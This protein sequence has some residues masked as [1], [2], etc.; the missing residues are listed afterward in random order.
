ME[1]DAPAVASAVAGGE[2]VGVH[3]MVQAVAEYVAAD[4][5]RHSL[6]VGDILAVTAVE[7]N[8][9]TRGFKVADPEHVE[10]LFPSSYIRPVKLKPTQSTGAQPEPE[11]APAPQGLAVTKSTFDRARAGLED[12]IGYGA[13]PAAGLVWTASGTTL[14]ATKSKFDQARVGLMGD[15]DGE[16]EEGGDHDEEEEPV[17]MSHRR[18]FVQTESTSRTLC[19]F[20]VT[21]DGTHMPYSDEDNAAIADAEARGVEC[22]RLSPVVLPDGQVLRFEVRFGAAAISSRL[23]QPPASGII[24]VNLENDFTREVIKKEVGGEPS[25]PLNFSD[26]PAADPSFRRSSTPPR[27]STPPLPLSLSKQQSDA[28]QTEKSLIAAEIQALDGQAAEGLALEPVVGE[29]ESQASVQASPRADARDLA[30]HAAESW[31]DIADVLVRSGEFGW[32]GPEFDDGFSAIDYRCYIDGLGRGLIQAFERA[33]VGASTHHVLL[34]SGEVHLVKLKRRGNKH[35][36]WLVGER[37]MRAAGMRSP[38]AEASVRMLTARMVPIETV[39]RSEVADGD[40]SLSKNSMTSGDG[41]QV[42]IKDSCGAG[43][44]RG[45]DLQ[46]TVVAMDFACGTPLRLPGLLNRK[47]FDPEEPEPEPEPA[48]AADG[49]PQLQL[50]ERDEC[51]ETPHATDDASTPQR[52]STPPVSGRQETP[53]ERHLRLSRS[54]MVSKVAEEEEKHLRQANAAFAASRTES[55]VRADRLFETYCVVGAPTTLQEPLQ[56]LLAKWSGHEENLKRLSEQ[57]QASP[58]LLSMYPPAEEIGRAELLSSF[59]FADRVSFELNLVK[60]LPPTPKLQRTVFVMVEGSENPTPLY[61]CCLHTQEILATRDDMHVVAPRCYCIVS[62]VPCLNAH[63]ALLECVLWHERKERKVNT[64]VE[65]MVPRGV[66]DQQPLGPSI[67]DFSDASLALEPE[68]DVWSLYY[69]H[70]AECCHFICELP[71]DCSAYEPLR[72]RLPSA[73]RDRAHEGSSDQTDESDIICM[74]MVRE[75]KVP[76]AVETDTAGRYCYEPDRL[77][78]RWP[79]G[80]DSLI[81]NQPYGGVSVE[82][83]EWSIA[84]VFEIMEPDSFMQMVR[85]RAG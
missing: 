24:Q 45:D 84:T 34:D 5:H 77:M 26:Q 82:L 75:T 61:G 32:P 59:C 29:A 31:E 53:E 44:L 41:S 52:T 21:A 79:K 80:G 64:V 66:P 35:T 14:P 57:D 69:N 65:T 51:P 37:N 60:Q 36:P 19:Y 23:S 70:G 38:S 27:A 13:E 43:L 25:A 62:R 49:T 8:G 83:A 1:T 11:P 58:E 10:L 33:F 22:Q 30:P 40:A 76:K 71:E 4:S 16:D 47:L 73:W 28:I 17:D 74:S 48:P 3:T 50:P 55:M 39:A 12:Q 46:E 54:Y 20:Q 72:V 18:V 67:D 15:G 63:F 42:M 81:Y 68:R 7:K 9:W 78:I 56:E 85:Q 2:H 6:A